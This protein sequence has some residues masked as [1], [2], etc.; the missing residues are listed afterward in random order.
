[1]N[2][3]EYLQGDEYIISNKNDNDEFFNHN[4]E[5]DDILDEDQNNNDMKLEG[6]DDTYNITKK[7]MESGVLQEK[8]ILKF[9]RHT[10]II[11]TFVIIN[12]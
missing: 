7:L 8:V 4:T 1:M 5:T 9:V 3:N 12:H 10:E 6:P 11:I 2:N